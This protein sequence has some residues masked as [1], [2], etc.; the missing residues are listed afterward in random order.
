MKMAPDLVRYDPKWIGPS[1]RKKLVEAYEAE[2][3]QKRDTAQTQLT[4]AYED[5]RDA[6]VGLP[7][8]N[9]VSAHDPFPPVLALGQSV[10]SE[11]GCAGVVVRVDPITQHVHVLFPEG[12]NWRMPVNW[13][14]WQTGRSYWTMKP[15]VT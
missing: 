14:Y 15:P 1:E 12:V 7:I 9:G 3:T 8:K 10:I 4:K 5:V 13:L 2:E 6:L 11:L